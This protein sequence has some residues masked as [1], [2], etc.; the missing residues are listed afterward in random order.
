M[1]QLAD[2]MIDTS[3]KTLEEIINCITEKWGN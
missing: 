3:N 1:E 2:V